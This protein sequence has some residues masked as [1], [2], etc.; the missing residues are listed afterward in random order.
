MTSW[1]SAPNEASV[2]LQSEEVVEDRD[3]SQW[4]TCT[5]TF[6]PTPPGSRLRSQIP[7]A[8]PHFYVQVTAENNI[9][10]TTIHT[11]TNAST[12]YQLTRDAGIAPVDNKW[13]N[14]YN[15]EK[16]YTPTGFPF[17]DR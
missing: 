7:L 15:S 3:E 16:V 4:N 17:P 10:R 5:Q 8:V 1:S 13:L 9:S 12:L 6:D 2:T 14:T 11:I